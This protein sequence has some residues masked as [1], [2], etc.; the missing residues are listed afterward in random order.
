MFHYQVM[1]KDQAMQERY[2]LLKEG[3]YEAVINTSVDKTSSTGNP[4]IDMTLNVYEDTGMIHNVRDFLVFTP[5]M[6]W[7]V[8]HCAESADV[9]KEYEAQQFCSDLLVGRKVKVKVVIEEGSPIPDDKLNG[10]PFGSKYPNK[11]KIDDYISSQSAQN[12][13]DFLDDDIAF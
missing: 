3:V 8:I 13:N 5:K 6:M 9:V 1:S 11:N 10:K 4:M 2:N 7:K 12:G